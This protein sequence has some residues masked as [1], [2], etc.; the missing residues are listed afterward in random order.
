MNGGVKISLTC[1]LLGAF[2]CTGTLAQGCGIAMTKNYSSYQTESTDGQ[3]IYTSVLIDGSATC[4]ATPSCP[5]SSAVHTPK[6]LN[7]LGATGGWGSGSGEC[8]SCYL[9]Y[10]N[11]QSVGGG[12]DGTSFVF[13][14]DTEV[15]CSLAGTFYS[16]Y[17]PNINVAIKNTYWGPKPIVNGDTCYYSVLACSTGT[18]TCRQTTPGF[19]FVP[20]CPQYMWGRYLVVNGSCIL[21]YG[22]AAT[23]PGPCN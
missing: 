13:E 9:T 23:G 5:C 4:Q 8:V 21:G 14:A 19:D 1:I 15:H 22:A 11:N 20:A 6:A 16:G 7:Q 12:D 10:Q 2:G 17:F 3:N 18:P